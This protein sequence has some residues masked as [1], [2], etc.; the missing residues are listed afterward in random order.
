MKPKKSRIIDPSK[1]TGNFSIDAK[2][3]TLFIRA[4]CDECFKWE[5]VATYED[6]LKSR[7]FTV[8]YFECGKCGKIVCEICARDDGG[9]QLSCPQC[10]RKKL[11]RLTPKKIVDKHKKIVKTYGYIPKHESKIIDEEWV[12]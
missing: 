12:T 9:E 6:D 1:L 5:C 8:D 3:K 2:V 4:D 7:D 11:Y 10:G